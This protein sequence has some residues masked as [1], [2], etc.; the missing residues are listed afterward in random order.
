M[1]LKTKINHRCFIALSQLCIWEVCKAPPQSYR[2]LLMAHAL[3]IVTL[4]RRRTWRNFS[5]IHVCQ[6][7]SSIYTSLALGL[8]FS[9]Y[10]THEISATNIYTV[11]FPLTLRTALGFT[12]CPWLH[13]WNPTGHHKFCKWH[14][15]R[16]SPRAES[17]LTKSRSPTWLPLDSGASRQEIERKLVVLTLGKT[18]QKH[19]IK[20]GA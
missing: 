4:L 19:N 3:G 15:E 10:S 9:Y 7:T 1:K 5:C 16:K 20:A 2:N 18:I 6:I 11:L 17:P 13:L 12:F 14:S 8:F